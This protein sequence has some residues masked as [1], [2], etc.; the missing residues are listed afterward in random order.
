MQFA[1]GRLDPAGLSVLLPRKSSGS[2]FPRARVLAYLYG[3]AACVSSSL[4]ASKQYMRGLWLGGH[5]TLAPTRAVEHN[6][7]CKVRVLA[8]TGLT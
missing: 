8:E 2:G 1:R 4:R 3:V 7:G 6:A 5:A